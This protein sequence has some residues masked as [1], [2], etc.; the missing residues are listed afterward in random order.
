LKY[1]PNINKIVITNSPNL[2]STDSNIEDTNKSLLRF[3]YTPHLQELVLSGCTSLTEDIDLSTNT[4]VTKVNVQNTT[5]N[6]ILPENSIVT[7]LNYGTPTNVTL[8]KPTVLTSNG[9]TVQNSGSID[10]VHIEDMTSS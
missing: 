1:L 10:S 3:E 7:N 8:I 4:E 2:P 5:L 9:V 6:V